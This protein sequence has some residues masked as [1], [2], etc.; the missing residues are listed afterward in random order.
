MNNTNLL[1]QQFEEIVKPLIKWL[2][3]NTNPH[4]KIIIDSTSATL[5][6]GEL[7]IYTEEF[8]KD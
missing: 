7:S 4:A 5:V 6:Y 3:T 1:N 2:A 8:V